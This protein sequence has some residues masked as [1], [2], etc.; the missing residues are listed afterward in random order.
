[1]KIISSY[2]NRNGKYGNLRKVFESSLQKYMPNVEY[3]IREMKMPR[4]IDHKRDTAWA[5][6]D[7]AEYAYLTDEELIICDIDLMFRGSIEDIM[8]HDFDIAITTRESFKHPYN[9]GLWAYR[10]TRTAKRFLGNWLYHTE[11]LVKTFDTE[12]EFITTHGGIDQASLSRAI[13]FNKHY[14]RARILRLDCKEYNS[15]QSC[16]KDMDGNTKVVHIKS[17]L[18][19][20]CLTGVITDK[21]K[22]QWPDEGHRN[23]I[24]KE[25]RGYL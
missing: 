7:A 14:D 12:I 16:W 15:E 23:K 1:M 18:R 5:F 20:A 3:E 24:I 2:F 11:K 9:T 17:G 25:F 19:T 8:N 21:L 10:P 6:F 4:K 22:E 13:E